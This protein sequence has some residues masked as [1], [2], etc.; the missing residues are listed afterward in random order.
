MAEQ[1]LSKVERK[2]LMLLEFC[3]VPRSRVEMMEH[4]G[5]TN[6]KSFRTNYLIPMQRDGLIR[7]VDADNPTS[8]NQKYITVEAGE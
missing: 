5:L 8:R 6:V 3:S 4:V 1:V 2:R 7:K